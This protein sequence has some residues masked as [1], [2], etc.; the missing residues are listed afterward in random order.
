MTKQFKPQ[1]FYNKFKL[2]VKNTGRYNKRSRKHVAVH[3]L[4]VFGQLHYLAQH[5][6]LPVQS[7]WQIPYKNFCKK[8]QKYIDHYC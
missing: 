8:Y 6:P 1:H 2:R 7:K 4:R 5:A 3:L